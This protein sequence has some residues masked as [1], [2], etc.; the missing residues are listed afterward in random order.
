MS[1]KAKPPTSPSGG[2][3][4]VSKQ[5]SKDGRIQLTRDQLSMARELGLTTE[6]Q[7]KAYAK[8][9]QELN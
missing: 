9:I 2:K 8:E 6:A 5:S 3:K 4:R 7:L 1:A